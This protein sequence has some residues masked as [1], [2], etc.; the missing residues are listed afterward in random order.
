M[1]ILPGE[2]QACSS[3]ACDIVA[4]DH[5]DLGGSPFSKSL[6]RDILQPHDVLLHT[7]ND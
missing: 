2:I 3:R 7:F 5:S 1:R 6:F 4:D